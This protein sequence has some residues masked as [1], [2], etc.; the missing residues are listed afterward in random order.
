MPGGH[1]YMG[2]RLTGVLVC[3]VSLAVYPAQAKNGFDLSNAIIPKKSILRG[4]PP[5]DGIVAL[6]FPDYVAAADAGLDDD[7]RILGFALYGEARAYP[8]HML[9]V[10]E[11]VN[12][13]IA[14][15][16]YAVTYC[17]LCGTGVAFGAN[18]GKTGALSFGVSGLLY[19]SDLLMYDRNTE[20]LW[21][22]ITGE[23][24][25]GPLVRTKLPRLR[26]RHTTWGK[27]LAQHPNTT[28]MQGLPEFR[29]L[30]RRTAYPGYRQSKRVYFP[31]EEKAPQT[32]HPKAYVLGVEANGTFKA[33]PFPELERLAESRAATQTVLQD[34]IGG[35]PI[36]VHWDGDAQSA[37]LEVPGNTPGPVHGMMSFWFAWYGFHPET[38]VY[39]CDCQ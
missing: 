30:Y 8:L 13:K 21:S 29:R 31:V 33:Y 22:Q 10:H 16:Y 4:G 34:K 20:S 39:E 23:S 7:D 18:V 3:C 9:D 24:V 5:R 28:V 36:A 37:W 12:D 26:V 38:A 17:P 25:S 11:I 27:W 6:S 32:Y 15:Q 35:W 1:W 14:N 19:N 2:V